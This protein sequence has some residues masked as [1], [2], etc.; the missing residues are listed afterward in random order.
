MRRLDAIK[1]D[2]RAGLT[3]A[4]PGLTELVK[5]DIKTGPRERETGNNNASSS[6]GG[7]VRLERAL[8]AATGTDR[9]PLRDAPRV[10]AAAV[11]GRAAVASVVSRLGAAAA[12]HDATRRSRAGR[13]R[14]RAVDDADARRALVD[15]LLA[16]QLADSS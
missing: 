8:T 1:A 5:T 7:T 16:D 3:R 2:L 9:E 12:Q 11:Q 15:R 4:G 13:R 14:S 6:A 10:A